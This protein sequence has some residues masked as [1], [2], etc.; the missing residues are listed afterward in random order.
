MSIARFQEYAAAFEKAFASEDFAVIEPYFTEDAVYDI[1]GGP[2][3]GGRHE[4]RDAVVGYLKQSVDGFDRRFESRELE[5]LEGPTE[6]DGE[7][8]IR[9]AVTYRAGDAPPLRIEGEET[10]RFR[11]DRIERLTDHFDE[12]STEK[13]LAWIRE[14]EK[15]L[16][17]AAG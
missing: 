16:R 11:G 3:F 12:G 7:V 1:P 2:P 5:L 14:H 9:W 8:W 6:R 4:G 13:T 15:Q 17:T 10:A